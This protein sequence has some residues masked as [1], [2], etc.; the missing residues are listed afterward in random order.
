MRTFAD[1]DGIKNLNR[2]KKR[3]KERVIITIWTGNPV[4]HQTTKEITACQ[5]YQK[6]P[7]LFRL[8][9]APVLV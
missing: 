3:K 4:G 2:E 5:E 9:L 7:W 1:A 6:Y 8:V